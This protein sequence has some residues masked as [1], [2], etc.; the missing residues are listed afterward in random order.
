MLILVEGL[1]IVDLGQH[2][3]V[4][5][6]DVLYDT[7]TFNREKA[8]NIIEEHDQNKDKIDLLYDIVQLI[9]KHS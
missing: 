9:I 6:N 2:G 7:S 5:I 3:K 8:Q 1:R 4:M